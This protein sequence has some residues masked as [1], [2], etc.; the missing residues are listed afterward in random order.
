MGIFSPRFGN[1][2]L[3]EFFSL[4][5]AIFFVGIFSLDL[6]IFSPRFGFFFS[7]TFFS[8]DLAMF[9]SWG[10]FSHDLVIFFCLFSSFFLTVIVYL[11]F[12][13]F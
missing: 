9:F 5:L 3:W 1:F 2:F 10:F 12:K 4:D 8:L 13:R 6:A 11:G 7:W